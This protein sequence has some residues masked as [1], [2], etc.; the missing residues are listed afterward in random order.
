MKNKPRPE[1]VRIE[2]CPFAEMIKG[3]RT[4][5]ELAIKY[6]KETGLCCAC[7][8]NPVAESQL[9]CQK[10]IDKTEKI[11]KELRGPGFMEIEI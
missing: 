10:C 3:A 4:K 11:L 5:Q 6:V 1:P 8:K 7:K 2:A 9:R